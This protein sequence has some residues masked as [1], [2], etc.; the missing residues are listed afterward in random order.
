MRNIMHW[1]NEKVPP[2]GTI[3]LG[4]KFCILPE[5][6]GDHRIWLK[7]IPIISCYSYATYVFGSSTEEEHWYD[8]SLR[9]Y[10]DYLV[11]F[12]KS[13]YKI[14]A[15]PEP[16]EKINLVME[17]LSRKVPNYSDFFIINMN[18]NQESQLVVDIKVT[19]RTCSTKEQL[20]WSLRNPI[21][22][23]PVVF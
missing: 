9:D 22:D 2:Y 10:M 23:I 17:S 11:T 8:V 7:S 13:S 1:K 18:L 4:R 6:W 20:I 3:K 15:T 21:E 5:T 12:L 16:S 14:W 19:D